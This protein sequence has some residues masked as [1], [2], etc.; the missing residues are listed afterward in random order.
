MTR[1]FEGLAPGSATF[2][3][4]EEFLF[5]ASK[6]VILGHVKP[7]GDT[8]GSC[9]ALTEIG[10]AQGREVAWVGNSPVPAIFRH[11]PNVERFQM[12][13]Q[14]MPTKEGTILICLDTA[15]IERAL[16]GLLE[17][18]P[19]LNFDHHRDNQ[20]YG[21]LYRVEYE[22]SSTAELLWKM[23]TALNWP[24][25]ERVANGLYTGIVTDTGNFVYPC[26]SPDT[27]RAAADLL[28]RGVNPAK[29][30]D[31]IWNNRPYEGFLLWGRAFQRI[32]RFGPEEQFVFSWLEKRD[33]DETG[34]TRAETES[35]V[36]QFLSIRGV[37]LALLCTEEPPEVNL[38]F[39][40]KQTS[41][42][43]ANEIARS[44][45]GGGHLLAAG[46]QVKASLSALLEHVRR[47]IEDR[48]REKRA[49]LNAE[50]KEIPS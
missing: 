40:A 20:L 45:G 2:E 5:S 27:H 9:S 33:F 37:E 3:E 7:D 50:L 39:R 44:Y 34:A 4:I 43:T 16:P 12:V 19:V 17:A 14:L 35:L 47:L 24:I 30:D 48:C 22:L 21:T 29:I 41:S 38:S 25:T 49:A 46:A 1:D 8:V 32:T 42:V 15:N 36:N 11:L 26:T 31:L 18:G 13:H 23:A 28:T 6:W 10:I